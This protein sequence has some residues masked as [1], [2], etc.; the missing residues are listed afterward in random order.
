MKDRTLT[1]PIIFIQFCREIAP[2]RT[3]AITE[4]HKCPWLHIFLEQ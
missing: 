2:A 1:T 3:C 4:A